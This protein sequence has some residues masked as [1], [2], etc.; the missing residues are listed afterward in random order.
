MT[1]QKVINPDEEFSGLEEF[2]KDLFKRLHLKAEEKKAMTYLSIMP[3][4][5][6]PKKIF[7]T[8]SGISE[9]TID[10]LERC[11]MAQQ[12]Y[13]GNWQDDMIFLHPIIGEGARE[14]FNPT[15]DNC[16][17][18]I[19][20]FADYLYGEDGAYNKTWNNSYRD[21]QKMEPYVSA[22]VKAFPK[23]AP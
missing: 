10:H 17:H 18:L 20:G 16:C 2:Q 23:P 11:I 13:S 1:Q 4:Q 15:T 22:F 21:N 3:V 14:I 6:V 5:G 8:I 19:R 9:Q 7:L 12:V